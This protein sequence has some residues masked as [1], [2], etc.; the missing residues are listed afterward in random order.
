MLQLTET[1]SHIVAVGPKAEIG[2]LVDAFKY[3]PPEYWRADSYQIYKATDG[4]RGWDGY[5]EPLKRTDKVRA[6]P[7]QSAAKVRRGYL[8]D[9]RDKASQL[10]I[11]LD[12][13]N[14]LLSPFQG[15]TVDD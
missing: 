2:Q 3:R 4:E 15:L 1:A 13:S 8:K 12:E 6:P 9:L 11:R 14:L 10:S 5:L 7:G